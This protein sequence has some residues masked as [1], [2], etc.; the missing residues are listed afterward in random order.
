MRGETIREWESATERRA[1]VSTTVSDS[2]LVLFSLPDRNPAYTLVFGVVATSRPLQPIQPAKYVYAQRPAV[3]GGR[4]DV[5]WFESTEDR[6]GV[7][8]A[9]VVSL[10]D[11][12][13][14]W[15][16]PE[17]LST[18]RVL[19]ELI[20]HFDQRKRADWQG[21]LDSFAIFLKLH[22]SPSDKFETLAKTWR[23]ET[24]FCSDINEICGHPAYQQI[25]GMGVLAL[26]FIFAELER[27]AD[28]W[29]WALKAIT[30]T[31][32]VPEEHQ[33]NLEL[34]RAAWLGWAAEC[35][36]ALGSEWERVLVRILE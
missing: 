28:Q 23:S 5:P 12:P 19:A 14:M 33:G 9:T 20:S 27:E 17:R 25:I 36:H 8:G 32:S 35:R 16:H 1:S 15:E 3:S 21:F 22:N 13:G 29:F 10:A 30:G 2:D 34:M 6:V 11:W 4:Y 31:D 7:P 18:A 24:R 26:P